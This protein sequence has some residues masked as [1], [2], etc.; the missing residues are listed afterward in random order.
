MKQKETRTHAHT[1]EQLL[2]KRKKTWYIVNSCLVYSL[3]QLTD[4]EC[5]KSNAAHAKNTQTRSC[6]QPVL[7]YE[8]NVSCSLRKQPASNLFFTHT[9]AQC[10]FFK[11]NYC[12]FMYK[13]TQLL[14]SQYVGII[15]RFQQIVPLEYG[16][17]ADSTEVGKHFTKCLTYRIVQISLY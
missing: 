16:S 2:K 6:N 14:F 15:S 7:S 3:N 5:E 13:C 17:V 9:H 12:M 8:G 10:H 4:F 1:H 11:S